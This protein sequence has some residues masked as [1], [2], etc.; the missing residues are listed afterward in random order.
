MLFSLGERGPVTTIS[1]MFTA[2]GA[3]KSTVLPRS[4]VMVMLPAAMSA[5]P[6]ARPLSSLSRVVGNTTTVIGRPFWPYLR[7]TK[8]SK[9]LSVSAVSPRAAVVEIE[10]AAVGH[11]HADLAPLE[12]LVEV[13]GARG[14]IVLQAGDGRGRR[15]HQ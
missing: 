2:M 15:D 7:L 6:S 5:R 10:R 4:A 8:T 9:S 13:A 3:E 12:Q 11:Q 1:A 14:Q